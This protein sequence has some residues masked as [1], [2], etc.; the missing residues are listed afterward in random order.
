[1]NTAMPDVP[2]ALALSM[3]LRGLGGLSPGVLGDY[4]THRGPRGRHGGLALQ[5]LKLSNSQ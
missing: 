4:N 2:E 1:M 3:D 5:S